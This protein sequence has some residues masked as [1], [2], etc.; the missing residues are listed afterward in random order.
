MTS[1]R[2]C[3][4]DTNK[5]G[6]PRLDSIFRKHR[7]PERVAPFPDEGHRAR[8]GMYSRLNSRSNNRWII[9]WLSL[10]G[11]SY[12]ECDY[13]Y[14]PSMIPTWEH[15]LGLHT[16]PCGLNCR[17]PFVC[18]CSHRHGLRCRSRTAEFFD[19]AANR[20]AHLLLSDLQVVRTCRRSQIPG[21][22]PK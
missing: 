18:E 4:R 5:A 15:P 14:I 16:P 17:R 20:L 12:T 8:S 19:L 3:L 13:Y 9:L 2:T 11:T 1:A 6:A 21:V 22:V 7:R 10:R